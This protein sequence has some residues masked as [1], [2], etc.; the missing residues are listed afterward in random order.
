MYANEIVTKV[1][2]TSFRIKAFDD[3]RPV[4]VNVR[5]GRVSVFSQSRVPSDATE[6][7]GVVLLPNQQALFNR[8]KETIVK[9]LVDRPVPIKPLPLSMKRRFDDV[10]ASQVLRE[11]EDLYGVKIRYNE[12]LLATC[13]ITTS[14]G[15]EPLRDKLD[16][17]CQTIGATYKEIDA[18]LVIESKGCSLPN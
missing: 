5:T 8:E 15:N 1:L 10:P 6:T 17:I 7:T 14:L 13:I 11:L 18:E 16:I 3:Q 4:E 9:R 12:K 2:G